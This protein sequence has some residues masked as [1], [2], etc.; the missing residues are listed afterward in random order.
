MKDFG[1]TDHLE[2]LDSGNWIV[3]SVAGRVV[4]HFAI[5]GGG[6]VISFFAPSVSLLRL[7]VKLVGE[8]LLNAK[9]Q[10]QNLR[11]KAQ[12]GSLQLADRREGRVAQASRP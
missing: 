4:V 11:R 3:D 9:A 8:E 12:N 5:F 2:I 10:T 1:D 7:G 6:G